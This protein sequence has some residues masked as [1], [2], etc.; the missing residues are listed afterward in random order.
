LFPA[1]QARIVQTLVDRVVVGPAGADIR[2][3]IEG[4][5]GLVR[6]LAAPDGLAVAA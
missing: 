4:L 5:A 6:D 2:L 1:E 3:R